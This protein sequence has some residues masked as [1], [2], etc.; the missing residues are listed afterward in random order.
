MCLHAYQTPMTGFHG[1]RGEPASVCWHTNLRLK[2]TDSLTHLAGSQMAYNFSV[3]KEPAASHEVHRRRKNKKKTKQSRT[4]EDGNQTLSARPNHTHVP[5]ERKIKAR[6]TRLR[7]VPHQGHRLFTVIH[8]QLIQRPEML[9]YQG[10]V[11]FHH[12]PFTV[13][14]CWPG[15]VLWRLSAGRCVSLYSEGNRQT[16]T[17][18]SDDRDKSPQ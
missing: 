2:N 8:I 13:R 15:N 11:T 3:T 5:I 9:I 4:E 16:L 1:D 7:G 10:I 17:G 12:I 14:D 6:R 18:P